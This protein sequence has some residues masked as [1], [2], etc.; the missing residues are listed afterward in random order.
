MEVQDMRKLQHRE[1][2]QELM[3]PERLK[4]WNL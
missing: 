2:L 1:L 3:L 4:D